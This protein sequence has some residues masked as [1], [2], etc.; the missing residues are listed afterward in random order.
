M[1][2]EI[3]A[4]LFRLAGYN[5]LIVTALMFVMNFRF[6]EWRWAAGAFAVMMAVQQAVVIVR[7]LGQPDAVTAI[8]N[9]L[10]TPAVLVLA[11][12]LA[13]CFHKYARRVKE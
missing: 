2:P 8:Q 7:L 5:F 1:T 12:A 4:Q 6:A 3:L 10:L 9:W 13:W 11:G